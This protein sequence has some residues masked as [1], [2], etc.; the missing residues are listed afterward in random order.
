MSN[1][2]VIGS[3]VCEYIYV[4]TC[5]MGDTGT[6]YGHEPYCGIE[7]ICGLAD[8]LIAGNPLP[9]FSR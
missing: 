9:K 6:Y 5:G 3:V 1:L 8:W 7:P 4:C 2:I